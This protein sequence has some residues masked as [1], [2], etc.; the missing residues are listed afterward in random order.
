MT[1]KAVILDAFETIPSSTAVAQP[2]SQ[3]F[4]EGHTKGGVLNQMMPGS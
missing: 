3:L 1:I 4:K 2:Y